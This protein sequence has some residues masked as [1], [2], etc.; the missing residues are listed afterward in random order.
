MEL[1]S[2]GGWIMIVGHE[3]LWA[4]MILSCTHVIY[5]RSLVLVF[6]HACTTTFVPLTLW[7][8]DIM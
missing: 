1:R 4:V 3:I 2:G 6:V 5:H 7:N 8:P